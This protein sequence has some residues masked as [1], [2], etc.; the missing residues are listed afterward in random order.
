MQSLSISE[1]DQVPC[2]R[3]VRGLRGG[4]DTLASAVIGPTNQ[5]ELQHS[6]VPSFQRVYLLRSS[7]STVFL[8]MSLFRLY[9]QVEK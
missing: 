9:L 3:F 7:I 1:L 2:K 5:R 4:F 6:D 8:P